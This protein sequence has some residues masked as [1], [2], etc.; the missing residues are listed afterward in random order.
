MYLGFYK[1][2]GF[3]EELGYERIQHTL[4]MSGFAEKITCLDIDVPLLRSIS[5]EK[6]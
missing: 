5:M 3:Q 2:E 4:R 6:C 1:V